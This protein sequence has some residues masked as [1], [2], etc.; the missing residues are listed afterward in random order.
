MATAHTAAQG[1]S[2]QEARTRAATKLFPSAPQSRAGSRSLP[3]AP[4]TVSSNSETVDL[5]PEDDDAVGPKPGTL[6]NTD[7]VGEHLE[8]EDENPNAAQ[9]QHPPPARHGKRNARSSDPPPDDEELAAQ[10]HTAG[11]SEKGKGKS[12]PLS[13]KRARKGDAANEVIVL[14][15][16]SDEGEADA[17]TDGNAPYNSSKVLPPSADDFWD[18]LRHMAGQVNAPP[19]SSTPN[20]GPSRRRNGDGG[21]ALEEQQ[22]DQTAPRGRG[23]GKA[24][25]GGNT[26]TVNQGGKK[27]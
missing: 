18:E 19:T 17:M 2:I 16:D 8:S 5:G 11:K 21:S 9:S 3:S 20:P 15:P 13:N 7:D 14:D 24:A 12:V 23:R 26:A 4:A 10:A 25:A 1:S 22:I 27:G 6:S